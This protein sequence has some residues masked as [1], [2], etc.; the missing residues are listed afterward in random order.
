MKKGQ[1]SESNAQAKDPGYF[2]CGYIR[3]RVGG[4]STGVKGT[5][6]AEKS[7]SG[8]CQMP[9][10]DYAVTDALA[11]GQDDA[12]GNLKWRQG[13]ADKFCESIAETDRLML[14]W[15]ASVTLTATPAELT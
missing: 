11:L 13:L 6:W 8:G 3:D 9:E 4:S 15:P 12:L 2:V 7:D 10:G 5:F 14:S 1:I